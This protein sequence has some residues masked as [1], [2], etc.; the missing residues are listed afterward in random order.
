MPRNLRKVLL[1]ADYA[2]LPKAIKN[3]EEVMDSTKSVSSEEV[4]EDEESLMDLME[5]LNMVR[6]PKRPIRKYTGNIQS[7]V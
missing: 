7:P 2:N 6:I 4:N 5:E 3:N 1:P